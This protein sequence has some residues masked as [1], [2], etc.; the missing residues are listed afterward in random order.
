MDKEK[1]NIQD[2]TQ[3]FIRPTKKRT[4]IIRKLSDTAMIMFVIF[5]LAIF[6]SSIIFITTW[7][8]VDSPDLFQNN[9]SILT[10]FPSLRGKNTAQIINMLF[11]SN[12][13][14]KIYQDIVDQTFLATFNSEKEF[15]MEAKLARQQIKAQIDK[16]KRS[17][18]AKFGIKWK[19]EWNK[20]LKRFFSPSKNKKFSEKECLVQHCEEKY[21]ESKL[22]PI[23]KKSVTNRYVN[24][25]VSDFQSYK[26]NNIWTWLLDIYKYVKQEGRKTGDFDNYHTFHNRI[27]IIKSAFFG[28]WKVSDEKLWSKLFSIPTERDLL[29][30]TP[31]LKKVWSTKGNRPANNEKDVLQDQF[32]NIQGMFTNT[33]LKLIRLWFRD[34]RPLYVKNIVFPFNPKKAE[35]FENGIKK[36]DFEKKNQERVKKTLNKF[37]AGETFSQVLNWAVSTWG[38]VQSEDKNSSETGNLGIIKVDDNKEKVSVIFK[39]TVYRY[40]SAI[41]ENKLSD[42]PYIKTSTFEDLLD[43]IDRS[44]NEEPSFGSTQPEYKDIAQIKSKAGENIL[45]FCDED[46]IHLVK[47]AGDNYLEENTKNTDLP[48]THIDPNSSILHLREKKLG[49]YLEEGKI[50][51][52]FI[53]RLSTRNNRKIRLSNRNQRDYE[54]SIA[55]DKYLAFLVNKYQEWTYVLNNDIANPT[56]KFDLLKKLEEYTGE[57]SENALGDWL[58]Q[59]I[60]KTNEYLKWGEKSETNKELKNL[61]MEIKKMFLRFKIN[62]L[63]SLLSNSRDERS[64]LK[65]IKEEN[66]HF[67]EIENGPAARHNIEQIRSLIKNRE[68]TWNSVYIGDW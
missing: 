60:P 8:S 38:N 23:A 63:N 29:G 36:K 57:N 56:P 2:Q 68:N 53:E 10:K 14:K 65:D 44:K 45:A 5:S 32:S 1:K 22:S 13:K 48:Y 50:N 9:N 33:Q 16:E 34:Y 58:I 64:V 11:D 15:K 28:T 41:Q 66:L 6:I 55:D 49:N 39:T 47:I 12:D 3:E 54:Y 21:V 4:G 40:S 51:Q 35:K 20:I 59:L 7:K 19:E 27:W 24:N 31:D 25:F 37:S 67:D 42:I 43:R 52:K 26:I 18:R 17:L 62:S 61:I 46:G 30:I